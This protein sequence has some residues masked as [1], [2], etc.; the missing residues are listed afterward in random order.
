LPERENRT[1][2]QTIWRRL[3]LAARAI[4]VEADALDQVGWQGS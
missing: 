1:D 4:S 2:E 3:E